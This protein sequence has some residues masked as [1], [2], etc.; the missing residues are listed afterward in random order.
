MRW[1]WKASAAS[2]ARSSRSPTSTFGL[3]PASGARFSARTAPA[4]RRC[5]TRSPAISRRPPDASASSARTSPRFP[6]QERIRRGLRRTYQI[7]QLF[8]GLTR[9][10]QH[11]R[12]LPRRV[13]R[14]PVAAAPVA[15]TTRRWRRR[16]SIAHS[17]HLDDILRDAGFGAQP[18]PAAPARDRAGAVRR[19]AL[20]PVRR[21][22]GRPFAFRAAR[23]RRHPQ[24]AAGAYR[25][26]HHRARSRRRLARLD[27]CDDDAQR[28]HLQGGRAARRSRTTRRCRPSISERGM[29]RHAAPAPAVKPI[30]QVQ[31]LQ[32]YYGESH[33]LQ[34]VSLTLAARRALGRRPQRHGQDDALQHDRRAD[35]RALG[36]DPVRRAATYPVWSRMRSCAPASASCRRAAG[37]GRAC[38]STRRC[39]SASAPAPAAIPGPSS[40]SIRPSRASP[41]GAATAAASFRAASSRCWRSR[42]RCSAI[43]GF[44]SWTSRPRVS[45]R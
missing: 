6:V 11:L 31:D 42:G 39:A 20:H 2:S 15:T 30:L 23:P 21:A 7:S 40:A 34:G 16:A 10:R 17:V 22:G 8:G 43:R 12:R 32:V 41:S 35:A 44:W 33:A 5:S 14:P 28:P 45:R 38:P 18:R 19:A 27:L 4:R 3:A 37:F 36:R 29:A 25:L 24:R 1:S 26:H 13:A 9:H